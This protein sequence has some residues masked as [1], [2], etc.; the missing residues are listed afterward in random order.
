MKADTKTLQDVL[1]GDRR[2]VVPVYQRPYVWDQERQWEPLWDDVEAT[3]VRLAEARQS[4]KSKGLDAAKSDKEAAPHFLGAIVVGQSPTK[5]GE[6]DT[7]LIVD[8]QQRMTTIQLLF[9]GVLDALGEADAS[10]QVRARVRKAVRNDDDVVDDEHLLKLTPRRAERASFEEAMQDSPADPAS[11][12][13]AAAR[14]FFAGLAFEFLCDDQ[15][16]ADPF[17]SSDDGTQNRADLLAATILGLVK[18]VVID[19]DD[20]D[21]AQVIFEALNAR[22]TPLSATDLVKNLLFLKAENEHEDPEALYEALWSR[23][24]D[25]SA[26]WIAQT[27]VGH[28]QRARQDWLLGDWLIAQLGRPINVGRL[29][30]EFRR[31]L[32]DSGTKAFSALQTLNEYADAYEVIHGRRDGASDVELQAFQI[33]E[34][35]GITATTPLFLWLLIQPV[36]ILPPLDR[37][38]AIGAVESFIVRRMAWKAQTRAYSQVFVEVLR[39]AQRSDHPGQ[40]VI[41]ALASSPHR[42]SWPNEIDLEDAFASGRYYGPGGVNQ[43]RL[44]LLLGAVDADLQRRSLKAEPLKVDYD[45]LQI[46]HVIPQGWRTHWPL[47]GLGQAEL[48]VAEQDRDRHLH[49]IGNLTLATAPLNV[50]LAH[51]PWGAKRRELQKHSKLEL[52]ALLIEQEVWNEEHIVERG[53]WLARQIDRVWPGPSSDVWQL[54]KT[55]HALGGTRHMAKSQHVRHPSG[56]EHS[57]STGESTGSKGQD[58][59]DFYPGLYRRICQVV[60][61]GDR[62]PTLSTGSANIVGVLDQSGMEV[63]TLEAARQGKTRLVPARLFNAAWDELQRTG[64]VSRGALIELL[65]ATSAKRGSAVLSVLARFS[66]VSVTQTQPIVLKLDGDAKG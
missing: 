49:C 8:G 58:S 41:E 32:T 55:T 47:E 29:Y 64:Q 39:A 13:F 61:A 34:R 62:L 65:G 66:E 18:L 19:L 3:A 33:V 7:R 5:T 14:G 59:E 30:G 24:D 43:D 17:A 28:A 42:Y 45:Q 60:S 15:V 2:F 12:T 54:Q 27:G 52:N 4:G 6:V 11:S 25:N 9:R 35:I 21:D 50:S 22:N 40:A 1:H 53:R 37:E 48:L 38:R 57:Q 20:V 51:D 46:E 56:H 63:K 16:P 23:F 44:R 31:W 26:W 36:E 10:K